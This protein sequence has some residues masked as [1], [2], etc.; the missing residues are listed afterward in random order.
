MKLLPYCLSICL[1]LVLGAC[2][3]TRTTAPPPPPEPAVLEI[4][5]PPAVETAESA[6]LEPSAS[7]S[8]EPA[9]SDAVTAGEEKTPTT[10]TDSIPE[11]H[12]EQVQ[13]QKILLQ[14]LRDAGV[15]DDNLTP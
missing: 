5:P 15:P 11:K 2:A 8:P 7:P 6:P 9:P 4:E 10:A 14:V 12:L 3:P 1:L 13:D